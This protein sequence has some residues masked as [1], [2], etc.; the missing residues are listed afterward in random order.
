MKKIKIDTPSVMFTSLTTKENGRT[1]GFEAYL[2]N[3]DIDPVIMEK[4]CNELRPFFPHIYTNLRKGFF[5]NYQIPAD[6]G[7][8]IYEKTR[9]TIKPIGFRY[10]GKPDFRLTYEKN[11]IS[12]E[13]AHC[14]GDGK[15]LLRYFETLLIR[16]SRLKNGENTPLSFPFSTEK[17]CENSFETY[18]D[19]N[20]EREKGKK[21]KAYHITEN[22]DLALPELLFVKMPVDQ[23]KKQAHIHSMT[24]TEYLSSVLILG[25]IR[26][27]DKE[28]LDPVTVFIPVNLRQ[29]FPS[30]SMRN[31]VIQREMKFYPYGKNDYSLDY[32]CEKT[33]KRLHRD[34]NRENLQKTLNK[35]GSLIHNPV[36]N[37]IP[38]AVKI[39]VMKKLQRKD[40]KAATTIFT[41]LG[42]CVL[43]DELKGIISDLRFINGDTRYYGLASTVSCVSIDN[44]LTMCWSQATSDRKWMNECVKILKE[45]SIEAYNCI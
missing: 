34:L 36:I 1:F 21:E 44:T 26:S 6:G 45:Q 41:N 13:S 35:Y 23:V 9:R 3:G 25:A 17:I 42:Q 5:W 12:F 18:Y 28:I 39:P 20:G 4:A 24:V 38:N 14:L 30:E 27:A 8:N 22:F 32:I 2:E 11:R 33:S 43:P 16:Y 40:H 7:I 29:F 19:S 10:D 15:G 31:F 37:I